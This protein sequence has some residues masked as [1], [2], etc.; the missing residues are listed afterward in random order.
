MAIDK[1]VSAKPGSDLVFMSY[2][3]RDIAAVATENF[4]P[5]T[6]GIM[7]IRYLVNGVSND[8]KKRIYDTIQFE[9]VNSPSSKAWS[10]F[11]NPSS[12][13]MLVTQ[14][15]MKPNMKNVGP[16]GILRVMVGISEVSTTQPETG[17]SVIL[18]QMHH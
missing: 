16:F 1:V 5:I 7:N 12:G 6:G 8:A 10:L 9:V 2:E 4:N 13:R 15:L 3:G 18:S 11:A 17:T 14:V